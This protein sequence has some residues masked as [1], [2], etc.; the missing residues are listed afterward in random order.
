MRQRV[1]SVTIQ[2]KRRT[3]RVWWRLFTLFL[4]LLVCCCAYYRAAFASAPPI[5]FRTPWH[6]ER[7]EQRT[8]TV[9]YC[10]PA[11][12]VETSIPLAAW[13]AQTPAP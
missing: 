13:E 11:P 5:R 10:T 7:I 8:V 9:P 1:A 12:V 6:Y 4:S 3:R 2:E